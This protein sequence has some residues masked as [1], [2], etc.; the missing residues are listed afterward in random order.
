MSKTN[1]APLE[2]APLPQVTELEA[3][4]ATGETIR[5]QRYEA[6]FPVG[7]FPQGPEVRAACE[8]CPSHGRNLACPPHSPTFAEAVAGARTARILCL[9]FPLGPSGD[10][11]P[12]ERARELYRAAGA[13]LARELREAREQGAV[14]LGSGECRACEVCAAVDGQTRCRAP[15]ERLYSL[16]S[17]GVRVGELVREALGLDLQW[18][19][20][21]RNPDHVC[22]VGAV[23]ALRIPEPRG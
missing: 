7:D 19:A 11:A 23:F 6:E 9:R 4:M 17:T 3:R 21:R 20:G 18:A 8:Q 2:R 14:V 12:A 5:Y 1:E 22:A 15:Q 13:L 10:A 16:E